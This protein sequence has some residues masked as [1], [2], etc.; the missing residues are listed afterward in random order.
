M[1]P[2]VYLA[3]L[4]L[5]LPFQAG[6]LTP[7]EFGGIRPDL[8]LAVLFIIGLLAGP[9]EATFAGVGIGLLQDIGSAS[10]LGFSGLTR[11]IVGLASGL[12]G[13]RLLDRT[14]PFIIL[15]LAAL[16]LVEGALI[17]LFLQTTYG[18]VPFFTL[19]FRRFLPQAFA[20]SILCLLLL[21][22]TDK[23][24]VLPHIMRRDL[25]KEL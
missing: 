13:T 22:L 8:G 20:T 2:R 5:L 17:A 6:L 7:L 16:S 25:G 4:L 1:K 14:S 15:F 10:F 23:R 21:R 11:G 24:A 3:L 19:L 18:E 9:V 12:I